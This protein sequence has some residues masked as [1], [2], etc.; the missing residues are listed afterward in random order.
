MKRGRQGNVNS[1]V[2][3]RSGQC[4]RRD[5]LR[6]LPD[7]G[8]LLERITLKAAVLKYKEFRYRIAF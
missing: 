3:C 8:V 4:Q 2:A 7:P 1:V 6:R 5:E